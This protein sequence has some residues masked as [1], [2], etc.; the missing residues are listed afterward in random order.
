MKIFFRLFLLISGILFFS[1]AKAKDVHPYHVGSVEFSYNTKSQTFEITGKFFIDDMENALDKKYS[2]KVF[3]N[4]P[5]FKND[6]QA[7]L[8]KYFEEYL[9]LKV[10]NNQIR[11]NFLGYEENSEAVDVY[12]ET[13]KVVNPKKIETAVSVLYNLFDDQMNIIHVVVGGQRKSTKLLYPDRY[14]YQQF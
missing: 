12:L 3:F 7:L 5:K 8:Q 2:K 11:I 1:S 13:E 9:K 14:Q 4:N 10:N 6:M